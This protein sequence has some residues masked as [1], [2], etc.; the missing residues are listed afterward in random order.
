[1][2][3]PWINRA[4]GCGAVGVVVIVGLVLFGRVGFS[5]VER[6]RP[7]ELVEPRPVAAEALRV[8]LR[9]FA[10]EVPIAGTLAPVHDVD[11]FPKVG[12]R[13]LEVPVLLGQVVAEGDV[14]ARVEAVEY[15]LQARQA[16]VGLVMAEQAAAVAADAW[17]RVDTV[18]T[19]LGP[20][21]LA[22]P[23]VDRARLEAEGAATKRD[24]A[25]LQRDLARRVLANAAVR[26]P[27]SGRVTQVHARVGAM[28]GSEY[29]A[30]HVADLSSLVLRCQVGELDLPLL[31]PG[32]PV[33][34][35]ADSLPGVD[36]TGEVVAV[37]PSLDPMTRRGPVEIALP[38]PDG[39][40]VG[41]TFGRGHVHAGTV[42]GVAV[43]P[44][45]A[46]RQEGVAASVLVDQ[47]GS[48]VVVPVTVRART[49][50]EVA[51]D[52]LSG[53]ALVLLPGAEPLAAGDAV[54]SV[55]GSVVR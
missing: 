15:G 52:G 5:V 24:L 43:L 54:R 28:V 42:T 33:T 1:M 17:Q 35:H 11:V 29:P 13:V 34:V 49:S 44:V 51:V 21:G 37:A 19:E 55:V 6:L 3:S 47:G 46:V 4:A 9:D 50:E 7:V 16:E 12:G 27:V 41:N 10:R 30:F 36:L 18:R 25:R 32:Q 2:S 48:A 45:A 53:G 39:R 40:V 38:N 14:L 8:T 20:D 26:A 31:Q 22:A 23:D